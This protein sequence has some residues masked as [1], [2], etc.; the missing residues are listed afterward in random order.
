MDEKGNEIPRFGV[1]DRVCRQVGARLLRELRAPKAPTGGRAHNTPTR[2]ALQ[3]FTSWVVPPG[4]L[5][6]KY[7]DEA[8][9]WG[10]QA[11]TRPWP[12]HD[13]SPR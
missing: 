1:P 10:V 9:Q 12:T 13:R 8:T 5:G 2:R 4:D 7:D 3:C 11:R 6:S